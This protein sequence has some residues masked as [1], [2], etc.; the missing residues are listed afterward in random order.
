MWIKKCDTCKKE[1]KQPDKMVRVGYGEFGLDIK[2]FC[3][4]CGK[5]LLSKMGQKE[6]IK[7]K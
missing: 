2:E 7:Q 1:V 4:N 5:K 3:L 6:F